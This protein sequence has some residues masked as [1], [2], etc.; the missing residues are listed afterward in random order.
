MDPE[1]LLTSVADA[2]LTLSNV[3]FGD[4]D[5]RLPCDPEDTSTI[6]RLFRGINETIDALQAEE[7]RTVV[8]Q[9]ELEEKLATIEQ[10]RVAIRELSTPIMEVW[11]GVLCL[12]IVG[13][14]DTIRSDEITNALLRGVIELK[15]DYVIIDITGIEVMDTKTVD[16]FM[17]MAKSMRLL[18]T[19]CA[20]TGINANIAQTVVHMG[21]DITNIVMYRTLRDALTRIVSGQG[22]SWGNA[23]ARL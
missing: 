7:A 5:T 6:A 9:Q 18:G 21:I 16:H 8:Y 11:D 2:L 3:A 13:V 20:L 17:R 19:Q 12:P 22:F 14:M 1:S 15:A 4:F 23:G 10:Q